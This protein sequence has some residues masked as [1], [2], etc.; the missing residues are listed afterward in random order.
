LKITEEDQQDAA[1]LMLS[2]IKAKMG[3]VN[4]LKKNEG[5]TNKIG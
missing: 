5:S 4:L 2:S 1:Q 3:I